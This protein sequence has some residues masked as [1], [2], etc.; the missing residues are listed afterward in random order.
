[1]FAD[2]LRIIQKQITLYHYRSKTRWDS[3]KYLMNQQKFKHTVLFVLFTLSLF[4]GSNLLASPPLPHTYYGKD[5]P[6]KSDYIS[7]LQKF[8]RYAKLHW[9]GN[10]RGDPQIGYFGSG[11]HDHNQMRSHANFIFVCA[12]LKADENYDSSVSGIDR[13]WLLT[14]ARA[15]LRYLTETHVT[16]NNFCVD[17]RKWGKQP[18]QWIA[19][20]VI[21]K[22]VAGARLI[23]EDLTLDERNAIRRVVIHEANYQLKQRAAS[24]AYGD[25]HAEFNAINSEVLAWAASLYPTHPNA[26]NWLI[27]AQEMFMNTFSVAQDRRDPTVVDGRRVNE[28]VYTV[29]VH[30]DF[31]LEGHGGYNFDYIA[32]PLHSLAWAYYAFVSNGQ[33]VPQ[34]LFHH[35]LDVWNGLKKTHL[36]SGRFAYL[37]GKDWAR[38]VY[39]P[40][41]IVPMLAML[42]NEFRDADA[43]FIEQLRFGAFQWEQQRSSRGS[44]FSR[45]FGHQ[46]RGW[47]VI[48]ETDC[49]AN[50]G[51]AYLLHHFAPLIRAE[52][53]YDF[54]E[55]VK[56]NFYSRYCDFLYARN[57][58]VFASFSWKHLS[59]R[60]PMA[61]FVPGDDYMTEWAEANLIGNLVIDNTDMD[62]TTIRHNNRLTKDGFVTT[63][64]IQEGGS[65]SGFGVDHYISFAALPTNKMAV[66]ME[67]LVAKRPI[68]VLEQSGLSY[69]LPNDIFNNGARQVYWG[70]GNVRLR[71]IRGV[72]TDPV[73]M[74]SNWVNIDNKLGIISVSDNGQFQIF[75][76]KRN[77]WNGQISDRIAYATGSKR[78][79]YKQNDVIRS[80]GY[81]LL[82]ADFP[83]TRR[84]A[85]TEVHWLK[86]D[87]D[88]VK[89]V[90]FRDGGSIRIIVANFRHTP[91]DTTIQLR[92]R[93][94]VDVRLQGLSTVILGEIAGTE[95]T[96]PKDD[97]KMV[98]VPAGEFIMGT[99][100]SQLE[101]IVQGRNNENLLRE[102]FAHEQPQHN[103]YLDSFYIDKYEV[104]NKQFKKFA[105]ATGYVTDAEKQGW[106]YLWD[107]SN[108]WP[109]PKGASWRAP[110]GRGSSIRRKDNHPVVQVSYNDALAY[111]EWA[112][113]R[114]PTEAEWEKAARGVDGRLYPWGN[115]WDP[116]RLNSWEAGP[117]RTTP[118][119]G[120][121]KGV[122]PYG[123]YD[124][125]GNVWE[126]VFDWYHPR[127]YHTSHKWSNPRG[128]AT[129]KHRVLRGACWLNQKH[130]TRCA[131]RDN[132]VTVPDFRIHLGGFRG[133]VS[134]NRFEGESRFRN[135]ED[136]NSDGAVDIL[137]FI[138]V[139]SEFGETS[140]SQA[141]PDVNFDGLVDVSD[142]A[143]VAS[144]LGEGTSRST[145][146]SITTY[147]S[148]QR[149]TN[150]RE[151]LNSLEA[152]PDP[153]S[154]VIIAREFLRS[155]LGRAPA[156]VR[157]TKL[158]S[159]YP[160][161]FN[162][163]TWIPYQLAVDAD[164]QI[165][166]YDISGTLVRQ[167]DLGHQKAGIYEL[168]SSAARWDGKSASGEPVSSG[169]YFYQL[170]A[171]GYTSVKRMAVIK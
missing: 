116:S 164:V 97:G 90:T 59:R 79:R 167:L 13:D 106:G 131:H 115:Q 92:T 168:K 125:V 101:K 53:S 19:P 162:P 132:Y 26:R 71:G 73:T 169:L 102:V 128:P 156:I 67:L 74:D 152:L 166:I 82:N 121:P 120:Y 143:L 149:L 159:N 7:F 34:S 55:S 114:L 146:P 158:L 30:P 126:W 69:Y 17:G 135:L 48:Y 44:V 96:H 140:S 15:G 60:Y 61:L 151:A 122:S 84:I 46:R 104:T 77:I 163:E 56:G 1:M 47:S 80:Q 99:S 86:T 54:Q 43:R 170:R 70:S 91:I 88:F 76:G 123:A 157:E 24:R 161:P 68:H 62:R 95:V 39:G 28:W 136:V 20:W 3:T 111:L 109:R 110:H 14:Q 27:K 58:D 41:F 141:A 38:H 16:G 134:A 8:P 94:R 113:K 9:T 75:A 78:Q 107:G 51:L 145:A 29:N 36:Y 103:V 85:A 124:M 40:Y 50:L 98:L 2:G 137:D 147:F 105:D 32:V 100:Q 142:L 87:D 11:A 65:K 144:H 66:M 22:A 138:I 127:Y 42:Q 72:S 45:R 119:G 81:I 129:G 154:G 171:G 52:S 93:E 155:W 25:T 10:Y 153:S 139:A 133:A 118:V 6:N 150:M 108:E 165:L 83:S 12:L 21:S 63:G 37:Q 112:G 148:E 89:A 49:Y 4:Y 31:T 35:V 130:V 117:H 23:W 5:Y 64:H 33:P 18:N 160:N 57:K